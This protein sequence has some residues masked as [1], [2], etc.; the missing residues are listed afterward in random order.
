[1]H[2]FFINNNNIYKYRITLNSFFFLFFFFLIFTY[3]QTVPLRYL[4]VNLAKF[5]SSSFVHGSSKVGKIELN[6]EFGIWNGTFTTKRGTAD[7]LL[8]AVRELVLV[9]KLRAAV[10]QMS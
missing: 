3:L 1:M 6:L 7:W 2:I 9:S 10:I 5:A 8:V 4:I